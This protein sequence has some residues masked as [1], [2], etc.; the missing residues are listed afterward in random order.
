MSE[1]RRKRLKTELD[2]THES[3]T[4]DTMKEDLNAAFSSSMFEDEVIE[5]TQIPINESILMLHKE[6]NKENNYDDVIIKT[7]PNS[8]VECSPTVIKSH[9]KKPSKEMNKKEQKSHFPSND[10]NE[11]SLVHQTKTMSI[12]T[13][14]P[15][16]QKKMPVKNTITPR[17]LFDSKTTDTSGTRKKLS[18]KTNLKQSTINFPK[19]DDET[20][21]EG[22]TM[23]LERSQSTITAPKKNLALSR[24]TN[25]DPV[26]KSSIADDSVVAVAKDPTEV[27]SIDESEPT[28][29]LYQHVFDDKKDATA[30]AKKPQ[31]LK[32]DPIDCE[33][34]NQYHRMMGRNMEKNP[35]K[36][37]G[38][39]SKHYRNAPQF[40]TP[41]GFWNP[42]IIDSD[43]E[44]ET[45]FD[46]RFI[47]K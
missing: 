47:R 36:K 8:M 13:E 40:E 23:Q 1:N 12:L 14:S 44:E 18:L 3:A 29:E 32:N 27:I 41:P 11:N 15:K 6:Y 24:R 30:I 43:D 17:R 9:A 5:P 28:Q 10:P 22:F 21:C 33:D 45:P 19:C 46:P 42:K 37:Y 34:C 2:K 35:P 31:P 16:W 38:V 26:K 4:N 25:S 39:C 7:E 20:Y